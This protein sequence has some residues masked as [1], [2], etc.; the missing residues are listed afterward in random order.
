MMTSLM[1]KVLSPVLDVLCAR[2]SA[3][4]LTLSEFCSFLGETYVIDHVTDAAI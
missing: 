2:G 3:A 1:M 4:A